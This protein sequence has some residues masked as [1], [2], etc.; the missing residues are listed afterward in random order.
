MSIWGKIVG[1]AAGFALGGPIGALV[2]V[3]AGHIV[4]RASGGRGRL[5]GNSAAPGLETKRQVF[6][7]A[8]IVLCAKMAK[9]DGQVT[10]DEIEAF[11]RIFHVPENEME[12]VGQI[13]NEARRESTGFEP[14][15]EQVMEI[16]PH[17][18]HVREELLAALFHIAQA[19]GII[20][21]AEL[22]YLKG[23][24]RILQFDERDF[25]RIFSSHLGSDDADPYQILGVDKKATN[26]EIKS[27]Y[28]D[29][30][31]ENHP[32]RLMAEGLPQ[33]MIDVAN[34]KVAHINDAY[35]RVSKV[36]GIK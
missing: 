2:G 10:R 30:M 29:L 23:V 27:A 18:K 19:D 8:L 1:G 15:A 3:A 17:N 14:Y 31:R 21:E 26:D 4:D 35:D 36:R 9:A 6:A 33:E 11:K 34:E 7:V 12:Q 24:A 13:F 5:S 28:R 32:D 25:D 16:F 22:A 20:H